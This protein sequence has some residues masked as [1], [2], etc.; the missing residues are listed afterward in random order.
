MFWGN[1]LSAA[2][3]MKPAPRA[4]FSYGVGEPALEVVSR[5]SE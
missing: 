1:F 4:R 3:W 5:P 2:P